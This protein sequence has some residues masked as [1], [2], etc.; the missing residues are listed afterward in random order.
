MQ[1]LA[2][3]EEI[4][5]TDVEGEPQVRPER[6]ALWRERRRASSPTRRYGIAVLVAAIG[7]ALRLAAEPVVGH[8][9]P[10]I[11]LLFAV[12]VAARYGGFGPGFFVTVSSALVAAFLFLEPRYS[13]A[14]ADRAQVVGLAL[15]VAAGIGISVLASHLRQ[16]LSEMVQETAEREQAENAV[17]L[18]TEALEAAANGVVITDRSGRIVWVNAAVTVLTGYTAAE[19]LA[20][21]PRLLKSDHHNEAFY[22]ALWTTI[23]N[24]EVWRG[25]IVNRRKDGSLYTEEMTVTPVRDPTGEIAHFIAIKQD[26]TE[27]KRA[28]E[29]L[30]T[31][32]ETLDHRVK[33]RTAELE[34]FTYSV[35]HDLRAPL[36][37]ISGFVGILLKDL[38]PSLDERSRHDLESVRDAAQRM[39]RLVDDLLEFSRLGQRGLARR[40]VDLNQ[41]LN[42]ALAELDQEG[43]TIEWRL[44]PLPAID[45]DRAMMKQVFVNLLAN[46]VKYT[47]PQPQ[48]VIEVGEE[49]VDGQRRVF[50]RDNGVGFD[51]KYADKLFGVFQRLHRP[52]Q[53]EGAGVGLATVQSIINRHGGRVWAEAEEGKGATFYFTWEQ[54]GTS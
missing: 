6:T 43:R 40:A 38:G 32:N 24:G 30:R 47:R 29:A 45:C 34:A 44:S 15:F 36:R 46:A 23:L 5:K 16:A 14:I 50:V 11:L 9:A 48:P 21:N 27:R 13:W 35:S 39:A 51:M 1:S 18:N 25:E 28:E 12:M 31:L 41:L 54:G 3:K 10:Y 49:A 7:V 17:R 22:H 53:F 33:Q 4:P 26:V 42:E 2:G 8:T 20:K 52:E 37:H 19:L